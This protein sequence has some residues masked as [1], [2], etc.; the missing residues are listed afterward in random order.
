LTR[1]ARVLLTRPAS[2]Q[3]RTAHLLEMYGYD[4]VS[5]PLI[6]R[7]WDL[8]AVALCA[9]RHPNPHTVIVSSALVADVLAVCVPSQWRGARY[10]AVGPSTASRLREHGYTVHVEASTATM[11]HLFEALGD[12]NGC[13]VVY[14]HSE[15]TPP[16][17]I[18]GLRGTGAV[19]HTVVAYRNEEPDDAGARIAAALPVD[20]T[21][22]FSSSAAN[23][24]AA[25]VEGTDTTALGHV[26]A[27]GPSTADTIKDVGLPLHSVARPHNIN[28]LIGEL[29]RLLPL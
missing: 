27:L 14:P 5:V 25:A 23:R 16:D 29:Q 11:S 20:A 10:A 12:M 21:L 22:L 6:R 7:I 4:V 18:E 15:L 1:T 26:L 13:E 3:A 19:V 8:D 28:G 9:K 2:E 17:R 24:L